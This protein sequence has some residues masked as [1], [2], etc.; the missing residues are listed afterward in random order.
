MS[1]TALALRL[2]LVALAQGATASPQSPSPP[3]PLSPGSYWLEGVKAGWIEGFKCTW[4]EGSKTL[5][6]GGDLYQSRDDAKDAC[7]VGCLATSGC[8]Y[9]DLFF[10]TWSGSSTWATCYLKTNACGDYANNKH[11]AYSLFVKFAV[12]PN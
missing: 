12:A 3:P 7:A 2:S 11:G 5:F 4:I 6:R 8:E 9:A 1:R 10:S